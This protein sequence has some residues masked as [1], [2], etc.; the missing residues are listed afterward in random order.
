MTRPRL[1]HAVLL[2][3]GLLAALTAPG[4]AVDSGRGTLV[5]KGRSL[6]LTRA[7]LIKGPDSMDPSKTIRR[8]LLSAA[9]LSGT[10][11]RCPSLSCVDGDLTEGVEVD[12]NA[13]PRLIY[14]AALDGGRLQYSGTADPSAM[15]ATVDE[16]QR[17][18]GTLSIDDSTAGGPKVQAEFDVTL[19]KE[20]NRLR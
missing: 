5:Y 12:F 13:G 14:W 1:W 20:F 19:A 16:P 8:V 10:I 6:A 7:Y 18:A 15:K 3:G 11:A 2:A 4:R 9:D 17:I